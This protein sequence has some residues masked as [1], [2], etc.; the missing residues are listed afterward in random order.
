MTPFEIAY[1]TITAL[2]LILALVNLWCDRK[3]NNRV[4]CYIIISALCLNIPWSSTMPNYTVIRVC[5]LSV[6]LRGK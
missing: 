1:I 5:H 3:K 4:S 6:R 2:T